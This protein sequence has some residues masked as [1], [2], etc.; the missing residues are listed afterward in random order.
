MA[1]ER[2]NLT[3]H[4]DKWK[5]EYVTHLEDGI[6][7]LEENCV[8]YVKGNNL[9]DESAIVFGSWW[10]ANGLASN[11]YTTKYVACSVNVEGLSQITIVS[12]VDNGGSYQ[13][14][15]N[16]FFVKLDGTLE[17]VTPNVFLRDP[18]TIDIP[19][20]VTE[21]RFNMHSNDAE[22]LVQTMVNEGATALPYEPYFDSGI[23]ALAELEIRMDKELEAIHE[24][25]DAVQKGNTP[26]IV[27]GSKLF[28]VAGDTIQVFYD[29]I[30]E[31]DVGSLIVKFQCAKGKNYPRY[32]E[33]TPTENDVGSYEI[34]AQILDNSGNVL[35]EYSG[36]L[37]VVA[38][39]NPGSQVNVLCL[40]DSTMAGGNIPIE[41]SR[42]MKG[43]T[44]KA[45]TPEALNLENI[46]FVGRRRND[47]E[48]V[49]W[50]G[51]GGWVY[52]SYIIAGY[53]AVR[54]AV[55]DATNIDI[56]DT[57]LCG[58][59][60]MVI[61][62]INVTEGAGNIRCTFSGSS[63]GFDASAQSGT[64]TRSSGNGQETVTYTAWEMEKYQ[65]FWN[66]ET[67]AFDILGYADDYCG[68]QIDVLCVL[69]G[70]NS[71]ISAEPFKDF[72]SVLNNAKTLFRNVHSQLPNCKILASTIPVASVNGGIA[73]NYG[74]SGTNGAYN[75]YGFNHKIYAF[76]ELLISL[77][78]DSEFSGYVT[79]VNSHAQFDAMNGYPTTQKAINTRVSEKETLQANGVHPNDAGY[80][81]IADALGF[82]A[83]LAVIN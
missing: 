62:E 77:E 5:N 26:H 69:L 83:V 8:R 17:E 40:G 54:F 73:A 44:G 57:Y 53:D 56:G 10:T 51:T 63:S 68:G 39:T 14:L 78:T 11:Q 21:V 32:W 1:Y 20:G 61:V 2:L 48:T 22:Y 3:D 31:G 38:A 37:A 30:I 65:P 75:A 43:T 74:A 80:W 59:Y 52:G 50:E 76:N 15:N 29:S 24:E 18:Y 42:R 35:S 66:E 67:D 34:A 81:Q 46:S 23:P 79:V 7:D 36:S 72:T 12:Y 19:D 33:Y 49:G 47:D 58:S 4:V 41:A 71:L 16:Y 60:K 28:A 45:T 64:L 25:L 6:V 70:V 13:T 9:L 27:L 82:R 55:S